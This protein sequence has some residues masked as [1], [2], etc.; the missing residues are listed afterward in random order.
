MIYR[1]LLG[2]LRALAVL[3][4]D[5][6]AT[7]ETMPMV[8]AAKILAGAGE[9]SDPHPKHEKPQNSYRPALT[10]LTWTAAAITRGFGDSAPFVGQ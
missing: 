9:L 10:A 7:Q 4:A 5:V 1:N 3:L 6:S 8:L 2:A